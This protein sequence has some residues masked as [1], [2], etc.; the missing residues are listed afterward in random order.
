MRNAIVDAHIADLFRPAVG[1]VQPQREV[2][3][4]CWINVRRGWFGGRKHDVFTSRK[5]AVWG[6]TA[7]SSGN[8][9]VLYRIHVRPK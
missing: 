8:S 3:R 4:E 1:V 7:T 5:G 9:P 2:V 6:Q